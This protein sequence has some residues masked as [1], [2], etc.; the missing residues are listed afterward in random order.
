MRCSCVFWLASTVAIS[1]FVGPVQADDRRFALELH[2][3]VLDGPGEG[4]GSPTDRGV[5]D[6]DSAQTRGLGLSWSFREEWRLNASVSRNN[7]RYA[8]TE[9]VACPMDGGLVN[10]LFGNTCLGLDPRTPGSIHDRI[11]DSRI[12]VSRLWS[13]G[14]VVTIETELGLQYASWQAPADLEALLLATCRSVDDLRAFPGRARP[15]PNCRSVATRASETAASA[16]VIAHLVDARGWSASAGLHFQGK[17]HRVYRSDVLERSR[18]ANCPNELAFVC[19][20]DSPSVRRYGVEVPQSSW[21][22]YSVRL[23]KRVS[24]QV[25]VFGEWVGG[26][27]RDWDGGQVGVVLHF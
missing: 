2:Y 9:S 25:E 3:G 7:A 21:V 22:W 14:T 19:S 4:L 17:R 5:R 27:T 16:A 10:L 20:P 24:D 15:V 1:V 11:D 26:G 8:N 23:G 13:T 12:T 6:I 18:Q